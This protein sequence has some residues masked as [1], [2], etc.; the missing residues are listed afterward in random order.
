MDTAVSNGDFLCNSKGTPINLAGYEEL[1][2]RVMIR[3]TVKKGSFVYDK[4]LGSR[5]YTLKVTDGNIKERALALVREALIEIPEVAVND[6]KIAL[7]NDK[8]SLELTVILAVNNTEKEVVM[9]I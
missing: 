7:T 6:V 9:T 5:L 1:L 3:L 2:Q 4:S 8:E